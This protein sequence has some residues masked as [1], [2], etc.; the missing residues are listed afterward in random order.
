M[1]AGFFRSCSW[2]GP[3]AILDF[4]MSSFCIFCRRVEGNGAVGS[5]VW[6]FCGY[7]DSCSRKNYKCP[8][9]GRMLGLLKVIGKASRSGVEIP[10][11]GDDSEPV[12]E[13]HICDVI[14]R[15]T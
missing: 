11:L 2:S 6:R 5:D 15:T 9:S 4:M 1:R 10:Q 14:M 13:L 8:L 3:R 7:A 12:C